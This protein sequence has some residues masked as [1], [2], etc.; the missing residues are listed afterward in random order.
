VSVKGNDP[1]N[2]FAGGSRIDFGVGTAGLDTVFA[3]GF[4]IGVLGKATNSNFGMIGAYSVSDAS[5]VVRQFF[6]SANS[7]GREFCDGDFSSGWPLVA[8]DAD[9]INDDVYRWMLVSKQTGSHHYEMSYTEDMA[10]LVWHHGEGTAA[11]NHADVA[12]AAVLYSTWA[13][14]PLGSSGGDLAVVVIIPQYMTTAQ[15]EATFTHNAYDLRAFTPKG[16]WFFKNVIAGSAIADF[17]GGGA[18]ESARQHI[19]VTADPAN[20]VFDYFKLIASADQTS[21]AT[22]VQIAERPLVGSATQT[23]N[24]TGNQSATTALDGSG[25]QETSS[26][27]VISAFGEVTT[28]SGGWYSLI[29]IRDYQRREREWEAAQVPI[30][31]PNDGEPLIR[32]PRGELRCRFDGWIYQG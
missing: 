12:T 13:I 16:G 4:T 25:T 1:T 29:A 14:Y 23:S 31:C 15:R 6:L 9:G 30:A 5:V 32:G 19:T 17:T 27:G 26:V 20:F 10:S 21:S 8:D 28:N 7:G 11:G 3:S 22:A 18:D 2:S 24:A